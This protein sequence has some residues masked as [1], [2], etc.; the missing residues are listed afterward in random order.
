MLLA[1][2]P[3]YTGKFREEDVAQLVK[4]GKM[5]KAPSLAPS[6]SLTTGCRATAS[7]VWDANCAAERAVDGDPATRLGTARGA[8]NGWLEVDLDR[9]AAISR[10]VV[11]EGW[12]RVR[13]FVLQAK[14]GD[15]WQPVSP[16]TT[17]G[18]YKELS[19]DRVTAQVFRL[20][21]TE[22]ADVPTIWEFQSVPPRE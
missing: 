10:A 13:Q 16:G 22:A 18:A 14:V 6:R 1:C 8:T 17:L 7:S 20:T 19:F 9:P 11:S 15:T 2:A 5:L 12:D 4:L 3:D 21:I